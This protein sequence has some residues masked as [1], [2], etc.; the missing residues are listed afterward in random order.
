MDNLQLEDQELKSLIPLIKSPDIDDLLLAFSF[1]ENQNFEKFNLR[2]LKIIL[3]AFYPE[4]RLKVPK[5]EIHN[6]QKYYGIIC[7]IK[8]IHF[9]KRNEQVNKYREYHEFNTKTIEK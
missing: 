2:T 7:K 9:Q 1:L 5:M 3:K 8:L 6:K 4:A